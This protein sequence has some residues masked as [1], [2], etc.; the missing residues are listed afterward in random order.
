V[1]TA[2]VI[3]PSSMGARVFQTTGTLASTPE[4]GHIAP[5]LDLFADAE[6]RTEDDLP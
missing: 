1:T 6:L 2:D 4:L 5:C 3:A